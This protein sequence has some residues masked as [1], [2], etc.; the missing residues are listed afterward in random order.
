MLVNGRELSSRIKEELKNKIKKENLNKSLGI[1]YVGKNEVIENF[2][3]IKKKF[4]EDIGVLVEVISFD[5]KVS[6]VDLIKSIKKNSKKYDGLIVQLPLPKNINKKN[7]LNSVSVKKDIDVLNEKTFEVFKSGKKGKIPTV[8]GSVMEIFNFY[9]I[10][11]KGKKIVIVGNG[12]LVGKPVFEILK[13]QGLKPKVITEKTK[14]AKDFY[15][16][17]DVIISGVGIPN[18]IKKGSVK[19]GVVLIDAGSSSHN[20]SIVGDI[21]K[22]CLEKASLF[23]TVPGG[24]GPV[25]VAMLLKNL[26]YN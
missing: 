12:L 18:L 23:S 9:K 14:N 13:L 2:I 1:F 17:A 11:L 16:N 10:D 25:T 22:D 7:V 20:G 26:L 3:R 6:E 8:A 24:V 21:S 4:G 19:K 15:K 5:E